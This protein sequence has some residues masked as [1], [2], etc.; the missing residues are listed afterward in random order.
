M[1][2][3][4]TERDALRLERRKL[5]DLGKLGRNPGGQRCG[6][7]SR[8][9][10]QVGRRTTPAPSQL[11]YLPRNPPE[12]GLGGKGGPRLWTWIL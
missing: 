2:D 9:Q 10:V 12:H 3:G 5:A 7:K 1:Y 11:P 8:Q 4:R 6:A